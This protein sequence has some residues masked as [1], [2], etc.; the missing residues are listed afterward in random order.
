MK[1]QNYKEFI[2]DVMSVD[3]P[4]EEAGTIPDVVEFMEWLSLER[5]TVPMMRY[6]C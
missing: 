1:I 2:D 5:E 4:L 6:E 3:P